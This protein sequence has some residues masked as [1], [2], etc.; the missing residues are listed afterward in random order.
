MQYIVYHR[1][2]AEQCYILMISHSLINLLTKF[3]KLLEVHVNNEVTYR[4]QT[5]TLREILKSIT[6]NKQILFYCVEQGGAHK[7]NQVHVF[8]KK[9]DAAVVKKWLRR[10]IGLHLKFVS[11]QVT[12]SE[13]LA[14]V[15]EPTKLDGYNERLKLTYFLSQ[16]KKKVLIVFNSSRI[17]YRY[18]TWCFQKKHSIRWF[19]FFLVD[20]NNGRLCGSRIRI[21]VVC[22][23]E[24]LR[25]SINNA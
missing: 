3:E 6:M 14:K 21:P 19:V 18:N 7:R 2:T 12:P 24:L 5:G 1:S 4:D 16:Q 13:I 20:K 10:N 22:W 8:Y 23:R 11:K 25:K 15:D 17:N 9:S